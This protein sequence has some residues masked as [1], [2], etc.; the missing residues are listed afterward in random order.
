MATL[1]IILLDSAWS[2]TSHGQGSFAPAD[3]QFNA[4]P[5]RLLGTKTFPDFVGFT[6]VIIATPISKI[7]SMGYLY[8]S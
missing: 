4:L 8:N 6:K 7:S 2:V 3:L 1:K 5:Y